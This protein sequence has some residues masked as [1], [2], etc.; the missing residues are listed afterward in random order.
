MTTDD[1]RLVFGESDIKPLEIGPL[2][3]DPPVALAPMAGYT[4]APF[5]AI[6][7]QLGCRLVYTEMVTAEGVSRR[8]PP[9]M[10][11]LDTAPG[12]G[13]IGA[14]I[15]GAD[16]DAMPKAAEVIA[17]LGR[18]DLIDVNCGCPVPKVTRKGAGVALMRHP[19]TLRRIVAAMVQATSLPV[20]VKTRLGVSRARFNLSEV[21]HAVEEGGAAAI[22]IHARFATERHAG[23]VD[24]AALKRVKA[25]RGIP[26]IGNGGVTSPQDAFAMQRATGVDG[27]MIGR[28][29]LGNPWIFRTI[30]ASLA[31]T[32]PAPPTD[33]ERQ[34]VIDQH[35]NH[36]YQVVVEREKPL[37]H[38]KY[39]PEQV[40]CRMFRGHLSYYLAGMRGV[41]Q[42]KKQL[43]KM[44]SIEA[45]M[46]GVDEILNVNPPHICNTIVTNRY[47]AS[48]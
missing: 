25:E 44:E 45:V 30:N 28:G 4:R 12:E 33:V 5:R 26:V 11:Y 32:T 21:A 36:L 1:K 37:Q 15:Y 29:A 40:T 24:L 42:L 34:A 14:H 39:T 7:Q 16:P 2:T 17:S 6:C 31:G 9:T 8:S 47:L 19:E 3:I 23:P 38:R 41:R 20:T 10:R 48:C 18:F 13:P 27:V 46:A 22:A 35:L 43:M